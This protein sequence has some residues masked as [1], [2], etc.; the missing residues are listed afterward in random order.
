MHQRSN[1][2]DRFQRGEIDYFVGTIGSCG[3]GI[4]ITRAHTIVFVDYSWIPARNEQAIA[5]AYRFGQKNKVV[6]YTLVGGRI[7]TKIHT[8]LQDKMKVIKEMDGDR[9]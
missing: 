9:K 1:F 2:V 6:V 7:D 5:R 4:N 8:M 3:V